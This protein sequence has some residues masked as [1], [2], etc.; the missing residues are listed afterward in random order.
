MKPI[1]IL[2]KALQLKASI[3]NHNYF[4]DLQTDQAISLFLSF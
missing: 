2:S 3:S 1:Q 4:W